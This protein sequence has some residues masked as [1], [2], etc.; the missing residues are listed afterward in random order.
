MDRTMLFWFSPT[1]K[2]ESEE[3]AK[4][5]QTKHPHYMPRYV[6]GLEF[7]HLTDRLQKSGYK[8][9]KLVAVGTYLDITKGK[10]S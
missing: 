2:S 5:F 6:K 8:D 7:T 10:H 4:V 3:M 1:K 9:A